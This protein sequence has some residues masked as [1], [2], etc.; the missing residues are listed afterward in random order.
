MTTSPTILITGASDGIGLETAKRLAADGARLILHGRSP[1]KLDAAADAARAAGPDSEIS[2]VVA[3]LSDLEQVRAM[4]AAVRAEVDHLDVV[5]NNAGIFETPHVETAS[6]HDVRFIVNTI[7]PYL[8]TTLLL[9]VVPPTGR[10]VNLSSAAQAPVDLDAMTGAPRLSSFDAYAQSKLGLTMWNAHL[11][12]THPDGPVFIAVNP[13][14]Y[15]GTKMVQEGF[16]VAGNDVNIGVDILVRASLDPTFADAT[17]RYWDND[18][19]RFAPPHP[20]GQNIADN[21]A[22]AAAIDAFVA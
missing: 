17:G 5:L 7:A 10:F 12:A 20:A 15:L 6:G 16:G 4:A 21:A 3:D 2:T 18:N 8:L 1:A 19:G 22:L 14:S 11:A 9:P 13:G